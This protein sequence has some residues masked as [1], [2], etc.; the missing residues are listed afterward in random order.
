[1]NATLRIGA[2]LALALLVHRPAAAQYIPVDNDQVGRKAYTLALTGNIGWSYNRADQN[3]RGI[4]WNMTAHQADRTYR[5]MCV[6]VQVMYGTRRVTS[7]SGSVGAEVSWSITGPSVGGNVS[8]TRTTDRTVDGEG[9]SWRCPANAQT[10]QRVD[11]SGSQTFHS[12]VQGRLDYI[13]TRA[14]MAVNARDPYNRWCTPWDVNEYGG[15]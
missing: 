2:A 3:Q 10:Y 8:Y 15:Q 11:V 7:T 6:G 12:R 1:M 9:F 4:S 13:A 14:C 5:A